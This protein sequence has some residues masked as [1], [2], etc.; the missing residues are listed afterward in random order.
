M[1]RV[2]AIVLIQLAFG[3]ASAA[4]SNWTPTVDTFDSSR[5]QYLSRDQWECRELAVQSSGTRTGSAARGAVRGGA[6]GAAGGA[7]IGAA[8]GNAGRGAA[9]GAAAGGIGRGVQQS[10]SAE[11]EFRRTFRSCLRNRGHNVLN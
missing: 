8:L 2:F 5:A 9:V 10:N 4:Q 11:D 7:A 1:R 6:V 3:A